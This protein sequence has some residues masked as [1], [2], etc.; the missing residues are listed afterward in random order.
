MVHHDGLQVIY[1]HT[2]LNYR[3]RKM[4]VLT[5]LN[6]QSVG[7]GGD[8][9]HVEESRLGLTYSLAFLDQRHLVLKKGGEKQN[10]KLLK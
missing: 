2:L 1:N 6:D 4:D 5:V 8:V 9:Q 7:E 10:K 3:Q